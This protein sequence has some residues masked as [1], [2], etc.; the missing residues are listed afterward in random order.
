MALVS[1]NFLISQRITTQGL[2]YFQSAPPKSW[3]QNVPSKQSSLSRPVKEIPICQAWPMSPAW[4]SSWNP[5]III[6]ALSK[7]QTL[8]SKVLGFSRN[9]GVEGLTLDPSLTEF[10]T[11]T[12][13]GL[14]WKHSA[15]TGTI[16]FSVFGV[17]RNSLR[18]WCV[19]F[20]YLYYDT[21]DWKA[22]E[23]KST[24][25]A[26]INEKKMPVRA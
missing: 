4:C 19:N 17:G 9:L 10:C 16:E 6:F 22:N 2:C 21:I 23:A 14:R 13:I 26:E 15:K 8:C 5:C 18:K 3:Y 1:Y 20:R 7:I 12:K 11:E 25:L 24:A